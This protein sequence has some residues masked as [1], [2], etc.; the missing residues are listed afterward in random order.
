MAK[1]TK[2]SIKTKKAVTRTVL[3]PADEA[4]VTKLDE[5]RAAAARAR[6]LGDTAGAAK[7]DEE[8]ARVTAEVRESGLEFVFRGIG[9]KPYEALLREHLPTDEQRADH[10][11]R[12]LQPPQWDVNTF[13]AALCH[14]SAVDSEL[15]AE[16]WVTDIFESEDWGPGELAALFNAAL[17]ANSD[18]RVVDL[19]NS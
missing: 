5:A 14:A 17:E 7:A 6:L 2:K 10:E 12:K 4:D 13:P 11:A 9:R 1:I 15:S 18:R 19:G 16:D 3:V 8:L